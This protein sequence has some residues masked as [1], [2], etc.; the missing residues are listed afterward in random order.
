MPEASGAVDA[1]GVLEVTGVLE[2]GVVEAVVAT[3]AFVARLHTPTSLTHRRNPLGW[4]VRH[5]AR[6]HAPRASPPSCPQH[7]STRSAEM[8]PQT[9]SGSA[10]VSFHHA[11]GESVASSGGSSV[12]FGCAMIGREG[13]RGAG[14]GMVR[15]GELGGDGRAACSYT[16]DARNSPKNMKRFWSLPLSLGIGRPETT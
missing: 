7:E 4:S 1:P 14:D 15:D 3:A 2:A 9:L 6:P 5:M 10:Y 13:G 16:K 11:A 8:D 12:Q